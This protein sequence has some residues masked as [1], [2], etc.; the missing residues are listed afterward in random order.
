MVRGVLWLLL[1]LGLAGC[2]VLAVPTPT[3]PPTLTAPTLAPTVDP[4]QLPPSEVP[5]SFY[6]PFGSSEPTSAA[7][8]SGLDLPPLALESQNGSRAAIA[9]TLTDG[10]L[11]GDLYA[12]VPVRAPGVLLI[13]EDRTRWGNFPQALEAAG[14]TV[15]SVNLTNSQA[16]DFSTVIGSFL[17]LAQSDT[18]RLDP[19]R[20]AVMGELAS[21]NLVWEQCALDLRCSGVVLLSPV[22][23]D[24]A[25]A[26]AGSYGNRPLLVSASQEDAG[27]YRFAESLAASGLGES[28]F[29]PFVSA[30]RGAELLSNRADF[31]D[32]VLAW[33]AR[34][35]RR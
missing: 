10:V 5:S 22:P 30:G 4:F 35:L 21:A 29:Q 14:Y 23:A 6:D 7:M 28:V 20:I 15:L 9:I 1:G 25:L 32:L 19:G 33:M 18:S 31:V 17:D 2:Q 3:A 8:P 24:G 27:S 12:N 13:S 26:L 11:E 16:D 34:N